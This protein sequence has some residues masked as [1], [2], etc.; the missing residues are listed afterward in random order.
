[1]L[2]GG[3]VGA[4]LAVAVAEI[5]ARRRRYAEELVVK[6]THELR[7]REATLAALFTASPDALQIV[8]ADGIIRMASPTMGEQLRGDP[9]DYVDRAVSEF[10]HPDDLDR[11]NEAFRRVL[12][13]EMVRANV[14]YRART[15]N[16]EWT[17]LDSQLAL[18]PADGV[19]AAA[20]VAG[21]RDVT[22]RTRLLHDLE[23][24]RVS[25]EEANRSKNEFLSRM[26]HELRTPL[27]A[28]L[29][30]AQL[31]DM[32]AT[33]A[34]EREASAHIIKAGQ[35]LLALIDEVLDI[36]RI[37]T[38]HMLLSVEPVNVAEVITEVLALTRSIAAERGIQIPTTAAAGCGC[39]VRADRQRLKQV[40]LN[41]VVNAIK[42]NRDGGAVAIGCDQSAAGMIQLSVTDTGAGIDAA[43]LERLFTPFERLGAE[44]SSVEGTG[45]G[46]ALSKRL[47]DV[48]GGSIGVRSQPGRG[49]SFWIE[50]EITA[51]PV[52]EPAFETTAATTPEGQR[53]TVL[54]I[55]D[56]LS[57]VQLVERILQRRPHVELLVA[58][59]GQLGLE[60]ARQ[61]HPDL[62]LVDLNLP[63]LDGETVLRRLR[64]EPEMRNV[65]VVV[66]SADATPGQVAR[67]RS[68]GAD[69]YVTKPLDVA[70]FLRLVDGIGIDVVHRNGDDE[71]VPV[72]EELGSAPA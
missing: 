53:R 61:H 60:L 6:R 24:A 68:A 23:L 58:M 50:L 66:L 21:T 69:D 59:Q 10:V 22:E 43:D 18:L 7:E 45:L 13:G 36:A 4:A 29:G 46:L 67:L 3:L 11:V 9:S 31:L 72:N 17:F 19:H 62:V 41:L 35:H 42:Y 70:R 38:G 71:A 37:E 12:E 63:D 26:S 5:L 28:V 56:N 64:A 14:E 40:L 2:A 34:S 44:Q 65:P 49:S 33:S 52:V 54:Y 15:A 57:N 20:V 55:E 47:V 8:D 30:F 51:S 16:G 1:V 48:M 25:A 27:N 32:E 39:F